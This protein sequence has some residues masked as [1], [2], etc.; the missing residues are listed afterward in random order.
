MFISWPSSC[1]LFLSFSVMHAGLHQWWKAKT[2][3]KFLNTQTIT[4]VRVKMRWEQWWN[5]YRNYCDYNANRTSSTELF[6][7]FV[8][9]LNSRLLAVFLSSIFRAI[10]AD[11]GGAFIWIL[12]ALYW[13]LGLT[14]CLAFSCWDRQ[15]DTSARYPPCL[16]IN[17][18]KSQ[19]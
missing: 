8:N 9:H 15:T 5:S 12:N 18:G 3:V 1:R 19:L 2:A 10:N 16:Q 13:G 7:F 11:I 17:K 6:S 4:P 14:T